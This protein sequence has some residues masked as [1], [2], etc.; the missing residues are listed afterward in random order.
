[1]RMNKKNI[2]E[3]MNHRKIQ[4]VLIA[5]RIHKTLTI[6]EA[7][8][9]DILY[10]WEDNKYNSKTLPHLGGMVSMYTTNVVFEPFGKFEFHWG[11]KRQD[12]SDN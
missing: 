7:K 3:H 9:N 2:N 4:W 12:F 8:K 10:K 11:S 1:M 5:K 6:I